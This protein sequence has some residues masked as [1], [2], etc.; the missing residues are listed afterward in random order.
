MRIAF[1]SDEFPPE[2]AG[3]GIGTY[4]DQAAGLLQ[5]AGH[6]VA[7]LCGTR[8]EAAETRRPDGATIHRV[9]CTGSAQFRT[10]V[11]PVFT[12]LHDRRAF[13]VCEGTDFDAS[14]LLIKRA[15]PGLPCVVKLH[16]P[17]FAVDELQY[18]PPRLIARLRMAAGALRRGRLPVRQRIRDSESAQAEIAAVREADEIASPS[19]A[20]ATAAIRWAGVS[21]DRISV[22]PYVFTPRAEMLESD[23]AQADSNLVT[24]VG[25]LELRK[26]AL[27]LAAAIPLV[28]QRRATTR[29]R[30]IGRNMML[31]DGRS[32]TFSA[33]RERFAAASHAVDY[34]GALPPSEVAAALRATA[35]LVAPS[36]WE[37]FGLVCCEAM[38][39]GKPVIGSREGGMAEILD[40]GRCGVLVAPKSPGRLA[41]AIVAL[42]DSPDRR[43]ALGHAGRA[44][45]VSEYSAATVLPC[46][47]A[48]YQRAIDAT[49][50]RR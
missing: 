20:I 34:A 7:V 31:P 12:R 50:R 37:S 23:P 32:D 6:E 11:V 22:F 18:E 1:V 45:V 16:T 3:G 44:R 41:D 49:L 47:I 8:G 30:L 10:A 29:F 9:A 36:H 2:T 40:H 25:R 17:R 21:R 48:S 26:G 19:E 4:L 33:M 28:V 43:L 38:A 24:Y 46:Q 5:A 13:D 14:A 27:D 39:C 35:L 15:H 42:L